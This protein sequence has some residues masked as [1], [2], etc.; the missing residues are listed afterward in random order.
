MF[1][2]Y[3][4]CVS[5]LFCQENGYPLL[6]APGAFFGC[7]VPGEAGQSFLLDYLTDIGATAYIA[8]GILQK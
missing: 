2:G 5:A 1:H 4:F 8:V 3:I 6:N 7:H